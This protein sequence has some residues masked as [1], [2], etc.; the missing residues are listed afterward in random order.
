MQDTLSNGGVKASC[1]KVGALSETMTT[2]RPRRDFRA[3]AAF[4]GVASLAVRS[5]ARE[6]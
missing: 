1:T 2:I 5:S 3:V 4:G 6:S